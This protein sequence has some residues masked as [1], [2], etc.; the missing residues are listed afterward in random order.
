MKSTWLICFVLMFGVVSWMN[1]TAALSNEP[2]SATSEKDQPDAAPNTDDQRD[3]AKAKAEDEKA[4]DE[5]AVAL[6]VAQD[7]AKVMLDLYTATLDVLHHRYFH[8]ERAVVP[9]RAMQD[10]FSTIKHQSHVEARWISVNLKPMSLGNEPKTEFEKQAA[11]AIAAGKPYFDR[12]EGGF[13]RRA[14]SIPLSSGCVG[15]HGGV[16]TPQSKSPKFA[17][18]VV[19]IPLRSRP[20][21][22]IK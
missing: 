8:G 13:Y 1:N 17:G 3:D 21:D 18:L 5:K 11:R 10:I 12:V 14:G 19:S 16:F 9:A 6:E 4:V 7:R 2:S 15:C 20:A 22:K